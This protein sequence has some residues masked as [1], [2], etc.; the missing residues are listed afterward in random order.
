MAS[1]AAVEVAP[2]NKGGNVHT[3][4]I[5][6]ITLFHEL[7]MGDDF[8]VVNDP[9]LEGVLFT[10]IRHDQARRHSEE[11]RDLRGQGFGHVDDSIV[12]VKQSVIVR[13][14]PKK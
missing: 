11:S 6:A 7:W 2:S 1:V 8:E 13:F 12:T 5:P 10:K 9:E 4:D 14:V 3:M